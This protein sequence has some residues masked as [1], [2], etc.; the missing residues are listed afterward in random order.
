LDPFRG[1]RTLGIAIIDGANVSL[2]NCD[3]G[4]LD[5]VKF[6]MT[7]LPAVNPNLECTREIVDGAWIATIESQK[8]GSTPKKV[9]DAA[10]AQVSVRLWWARP[11]A[12]LKTG[13]DCK[14]QSVLET[15]T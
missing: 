5:Y 13:E 3:L 2:P 10:L 14:G 11:L 8:F 4:R 15:M 1:T 9:K 6:A 12:E 7:T